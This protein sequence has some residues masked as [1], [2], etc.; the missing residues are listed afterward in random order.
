V[1]LEGEECLLDDVCADDDQ[2]G[3]AEIVINNE[4]RATV[5]PQHRHYQ[6]R[7]NF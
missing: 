5:I 1:L 6:Y 4:G 7:G 2:P 3:A